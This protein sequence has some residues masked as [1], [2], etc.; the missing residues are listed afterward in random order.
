MDAW[1][2]LAPLGRGVGCTSHG[3]DVKGI[4]VVL[5]NLNDAFL[6]RSRIRPEPACFYTVGV[7]YF[8]CSTQ[9][10]VLLVFCRAVSVSSF[11]IDRNISD[12][13]YTGLVAG[14][15]FISPFTVIFFIGQYHIV[16]VEIISYFAVQPAGLKQG[17][18]HLIVEFP[19]DVKFMHNTCRRVFNQ[20]TGTGELSASPE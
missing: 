8:E 16:I 4:G 6:V 7:Q 17:L 20:L 14:G 9:G 10:F 3:A 11:D 13:S 5:D 15:L 1:P 18:D 19:V 2:K 12:G